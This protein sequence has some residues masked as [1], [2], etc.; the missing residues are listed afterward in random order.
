MTSEHVDGEDPDRF[1]AIIRVDWGVMRRWKY[2]HAVRE[3]E[4]TDANRDDMKHLWQVETPTRL[5]C[6]QV[7]KSLYIPGPFSRGGFGGG[8]PRCTGCCRALG[9]PPGTGSPRNCD[10]WREILGLD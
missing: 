8:L 3:T 4:W 1:I 10:A 6:G 2:L 9:G 5:A 7:A